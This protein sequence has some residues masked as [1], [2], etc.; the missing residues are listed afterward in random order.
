MSFAVV[1]LA[2][3]SERK[4]IDDWIPKQFE[5]CS[6]LDCFGDLI[7]SLVFCVFGLD[8]SLSFLVFTIITVAAPLST[9]SIPRL[10]I[11]ANSNKIYY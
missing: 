5:D 11:I 10:I 8:Q 1:C 6:Y 7:L 2:A 3:A 9:N 4:A